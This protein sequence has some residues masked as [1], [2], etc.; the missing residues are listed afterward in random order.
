MQVNFESLSYSPRKVRL[1][2]AKVNETSIPPRESVSYSKET[3]TIT[4]E[5]VDKD[6]TY[7]MAY[8]VDFG[9]VCCLHYRQL[10][11]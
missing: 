5:P 7:L 10:I 4:A 6:G 2:V 1:S 8:L 9:H 3:Q 11:K